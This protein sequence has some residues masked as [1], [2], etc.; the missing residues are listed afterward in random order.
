MTSFSKRAAQIIITVSF[1]VAG[2]WLARQ[3]WML[4]LGALTATPFLLLAQR[5]R[6]WFL[7]AALL[8][9]IL[10]LWRGGV[11]QQQQGIWTSLYGQKM[12]ITG[13]VADDPLRNEKGHMRFVMSDLRIDT[14]S[15]PGEL[16]VRSHYISLERGF[17]IRA[18][19]KVE[20]YQFGPQ[21]G[22][23]GFASVEVLSREVGWMDTLR[24]RFF[25]GIRN[26]LPEPLAGFGLSLLAG[27]RT[28][29]PREL[30]ND[31]AVTGLTHIIA[32]S[33]YNLTII[34]RGVGR[35][36]SRS[37]LFLSTAA[38]LWLIAAFV[39]FTGGSASI[40][41]AAIV[42]VLA[43]LTAYYGYR[44]RPLALIALAVGITAFHNPALPFKDLGWQLSFLAFF[45]ILV[46]APLARERW[47]PRGGFVSGMI[48][49]SLAAQLM[50]LPLIMHHFN[51]ASLIAP[52]ANMAVLPLIPVAMLAVFT[53]ALAGMIAPVLSGWVGVP[54]QALLGLIL[55][56]ISRLAQHDWAGQAWR[57]SADE[58]AIAQMCIVL[59]TLLLWY[60][61]RRRRVPTDI[62]S[63]QKEELCPDILSGRLLSIKK[64]S[65]MP[66]GDSRSPS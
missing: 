20:A 52:V 60:G 49:E 28:A 47:L 59:L 37:S 66:G 36:L 16:K 33:G 53:A 25:S 26:A 43:L 65:S 5:S 9:L 57:I 46:I 17:I 32:V 13:R 44:I 45:G 51:Q 63:A 14:R 22:E 48:I 39:V 27:V 55:S 34:I 30:Q 7:A 35:V 2:L 1:M 10:G 50:T 38:S 18:T 31:L 54:A 58:L 64:P 61:V 11:H 23:I 24:Q 62:I 42:S 56:L 21:S 40:V 19:G 15:I 12:V 41:R 6:W 3:G 29:L 8:G 4:A